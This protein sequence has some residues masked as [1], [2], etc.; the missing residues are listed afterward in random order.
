MKEYFAQQ[1]ADAR[2]VTIEAIEEMRSNRRS[3]A[4]IAGMPPERVEEL[5]KAARLDTDELVGKRML[6]YMLRS[7]GKLEVL[8]IID[9]ELDQM[10]SLV[11]ERMSAATPIFKRA[12]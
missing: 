8:R 4:G 5:I 10:E 6:F 2:P 7:E 1:L 9:D 3:A 11:F 12:L